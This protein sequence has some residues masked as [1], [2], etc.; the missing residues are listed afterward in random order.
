MAKKVKKVMME[1]KTNVVPSFNNVIIS[2]D[3]Y[4]EEECKTSGG[5]YFARKNMIK[6]HQRI[7]AV[8]CLAEKYFSVGDLVEVDVRRFVRPSHKEGKRTADLVEDDYS[9]MVDFLMVDV[10]GEECILIQDR[11]ILYKFEMKKKEVE[12][13]EFD[14]NPAFVIPDKKIIL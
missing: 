3:R 8:G 12:V 5:V 14:S 6:P 1:V 10:E 13:E 9:L 4:T 7:I 11:D 2:C